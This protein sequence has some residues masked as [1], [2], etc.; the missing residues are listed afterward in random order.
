MGGSRCKTNLQET[1]SLE[2]I[3]SLVVFVVRSRLQGK[4]MFFRKMNDIEGLSFLQ[5]RSPKRYEIHNVKE[6]R[7]EKI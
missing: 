2:V 4:M 6:T 1:F 3:V 7:E 5:R